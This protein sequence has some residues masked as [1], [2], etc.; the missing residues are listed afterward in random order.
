MLCHHLKV[1]KD[2]IEEFVDDS[3]G[4]EDVADEK[5][6]NEDLAN[7]DNE[8]DKNE[9]NHEELD[10][11]DLELTKQKVVLKLKFGNW[12]WITKTIVCTTL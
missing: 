4:N 8:V 7:Q 2:K 6:A 9:A 10:E 11:A 1:F 12:H 5:V 3:K